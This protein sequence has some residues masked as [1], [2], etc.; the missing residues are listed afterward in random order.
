MAQS[1]S[2]HQLAVELRQQ[3]FSL[4][5]IARRIHVHKSVVGRWVAHVPFSQHSD[6]SRAEQL[7]H[8]RDPQLYNQALRLREQGWSLAMIAAELGVAKSTL[9]GW[10]T[11][12]KPEHGQII[13]QRRLDGHQRTVQTTQQ[14]H[15]TYKTAIHDG[16]IA[17]VQT[18]LGHAFNQRDLFVAGLMLYWAEGGKT[19][20]Q[21]AI[22][23]SDPL[24]IQTGIRWLKQCLNVSI[25][26][27]RAE[28]HCYPDTDILAT[29]AYWISITQIPL[30]QFYKPQIDTRV[31]KSLEKCG[32]LQYGTLHVKVIGKGS[33]D[34][35]RK[36]MGWIAGLGQILTDNTRE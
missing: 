7:A 4:A 5:Q 27:L 36:I 9:S 14:R 10:L 31:N 35:H 29:Q 18:M 34:L 23:N 1:S 12:L 20:N 24:V 28:I 33:S 26:R 8:F 17:E 13:K 25:E 6:A 2:L 16:A 32:K 22:T 3:G 21:I 30:A 19:Q 15:A 11:H